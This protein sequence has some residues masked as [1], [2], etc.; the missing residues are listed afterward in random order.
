MT[1]LYLRFS[2]QGGGIK[3]A[4]SGKRGGWGTTATFLAAKTAVQTKWCAPAHGQDQITS[5][6]SA[7]IP[8]ISVDLLPQ[9][10]QNIITGML[11]NCLTWRKKVLMKNAP[12]NS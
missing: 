1:P 5:P 10:V 4:K 9:I 12:T 8:D 11:V 2:P 3:G 6:G 7:T